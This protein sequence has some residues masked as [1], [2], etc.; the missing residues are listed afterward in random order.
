MT[1]KVVLQKLIRQKNQ[2][3][4]SIKGVTGY[5][6]SLR[7]KKVNLHRSTVNDFNTGVTCVDY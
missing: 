4:L 1:R 2:I 5:G 7:F 3:P 6:C